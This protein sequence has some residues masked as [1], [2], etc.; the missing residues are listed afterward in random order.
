MS[1]LTLGT[2]GHID[3][4]KTALVEA[5]TGKNTDRLAEEHRR[6][7]SIE[8][9]Y[10][11]L[12]LPGDRWLSVVDV[13]GHEALVRTMVAGATG[14][15]L[16]L[17]V[18]AADEGVMPQTREHLTVLRALG[19]PVGVVALTR[20]DLADPER[21]A[22]A[23][24]EAG[25][26][27]DAPLVE[28]SAVTGEGLD[29]LR[30]ELAA[31]A[32]RAET[33][34]P[35]PS[36]QQPAVL[37]VDR[38]FTLRGIG[39]VVTGT[40]WSGS[41]AVGDLVEVLP[42]SSQLR[43]RSLQVHDT[44]VERAEAGQRVALNVVG[45]DR[46]A[47]E[48][49]DVVSSAGSRLGPT[50]RLDVRLE[51]PLALADVPRRVQVHHGTRRT[52]ARVVPLD[53]SGL[54]QLRLEAPLIARARDRF[55]VRSIAPV[56]TLCGGEV[57]DPAPARHG[58]GP[59]AG[60]LRAMAAGPADELLELALGEAAAGDRTG[61]SVP[62]DPV[63][64]VGHPLLGPARDRFA[65]ER[66]RS[67]MEALLESGR[68]VE[69]G[70]S[71]V[72]PG[73]AVEPKPAPPPEPH[74]AAVRALELIRADGA[75]P[76]APAAVAE[77]LGWRP[78]D[79]E[80]ALEL[81]AAS[82]HA[83]RV[84]PGVY[85]DSGT[86]NRLRARLLELAADRDGAI[87]LAE[88]RDELETSRKYAQALLEHLDASQMTIRRGDRHVLRRAARDSSHV[89]RQGSGGPSGPQSQQ[90]DVDHRLEGS[91]PSPPRRS[92]RSVMRGRP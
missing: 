74:E 81:L 22:L 73:A 47:L 76:R 56:G 3:H 32:A 15:D 23:A 41:L 28:V 82:G 39:T 24:A 70:R 5:L 46:D 18:I 53:D 90:G 78:R 86:L 54:A 2:A 21:R 58:P 44:P 31:A 63:D 27:I 65:P 19:V 72:A 92:D 88:A 13:P 6:G 84:K 79:A 48:R 71:L 51:P 64:W 61:V 55:V 42:K 14:I 60:R 57:I 4:G 67:A 7:I 91:I 75:S 50:Y 9:G 49:G 1:S 30:G 37:H 52:A 69:R 20:A 35:E 59:A 77:A 66:W 43:I 29:R 83:V 80:A 85:Y 87:T 45:A 8:L 10:A 33:N 36:W 38:V 68:A 89:G 11:R 62:A 34:R 16:F 40:L 25:E 17:M 12:E 26:L